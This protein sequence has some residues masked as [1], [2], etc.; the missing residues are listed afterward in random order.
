MS[1]PAKYL[2]DTVFDSMSDPSNHS[3]ANAEAEQQ[4]LEEELEAERQRFYEDGYE[5]GHR[6]AVESME[7]AISQ[8]M[9]TV[10]ARF[11][12]AVGSFDNAVALG[13]ADAIKISTSVVTKLCAALNDRDPLAGL[14][15]FLE[16]ALSDL[17]S[18]PQLVVYVA[19]DLVA[20]V[21]ARM[22]FVTSAASFSGKIDIK[23]RTDLPLRDAVV[24][25][26]DGR[27]AYTPS[28]LDDKIDEMVAAYLAQGDSAMSN[29]SSGGTHG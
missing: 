14:E 27:V 28:A 10:L 15:P 2:F 6:D 11:D 4:R 12:Q 29:S 21:E 9:E 16:T 26:E 25:W 5:A 19:E 8:S 23:G 1:E 7:A 13:R 20:E 18:V 3:R 17:R 24:E 22:M